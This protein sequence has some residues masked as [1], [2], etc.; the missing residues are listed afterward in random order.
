MRALALCLSLV[1]AACAHETLHVRSEGGTGFAFTRGF[2]VLA[3]DGAGGALIGQVDAALKARG[4]APAAEPARGY[5]VEVGLDRRSGFTSARGGAGWIA[6]P[7]SG[8]AIYHLE[9]RFLDGMTG[10]EIYRVTAEERGAAADERAVA[11]KLV[12]AALSELP[13]IQMEPMPLIPPAG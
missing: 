7:A 13:R 4:L 9:L 3:A 11:A 12:K 6:P 8:N 1:V 2:T 5:L 10:S